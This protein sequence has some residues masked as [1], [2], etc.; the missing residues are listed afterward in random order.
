[1][2][3]SHIVVAKRMDGWTIRRTNESSLKIAHKSKD[4]LIKQKRVI[5]KKV[6]S[7]III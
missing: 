2:R 1:M 7:L 6:I 5:S 4:R 3:K